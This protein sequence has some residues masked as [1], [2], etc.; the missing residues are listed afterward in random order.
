MNIK[1]IL[2]ISTLATAISTTSLNADVLIMQDFANFDTN[3]ITNLDS[4]AEMVEIDKNKA[5][6]ATLGN[7]NP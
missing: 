6:K 5:I 7:T 2:T 3:K 1:S 4:T